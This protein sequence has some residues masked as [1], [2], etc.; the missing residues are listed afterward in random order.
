MSSRIRYGV[1]AG[2]LLA[3]C[4]QEAVQPSRTFVW[5]TA[6][7]PYKCAVGGSNVPAIGDQARIAQAIYPEPQEQAP[8]EEALLEIY[9]EL[10]RDIQKTQPDAEYRRIVI[11]IFDTAEDIK[12]DPRAWLC[13]L[14]VTP[15]P[16][17]KFPEQPHEFV[18]WQW[19]DPAQRPTD[20]ERQV[21]WEYLAELDDI[22]ASVQ[23][24]I[25]DS[26][27]IGMD[28]AE[29]RRYLENRY[30][31]D[32]EDLKHDTAQAHGMSVDELQAL[33]DRIMQWKYQNES[34]PQAAAQAAGEPPSEANSSGVQGE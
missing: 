2:L 13:W 17:E 30:S 33:L 7:R 9:G 21:E 3:G 26:E 11:S 1:L 28:A 12:H 27:Y 8:V 4:G 34:L 16:G 10:M 29:R 24:P 20:R 5:D 31:V 14:S 19:R 32:V 15:Q 23:F 25:T 6:E 18:Q 22:N